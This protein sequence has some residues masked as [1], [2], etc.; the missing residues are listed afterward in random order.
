MKTKNL[1]KRFSPAFAS[2]LLVVVLFASCKDDQRTKYVCNCEEN[3]QIDEFISKNIKNSN[4]MSDEEMEDV[5]YELYKTAVRIK[6]KQK[7][8]WVNNEGVPD[9]QRSGLDSCERV[10][11]NVSMY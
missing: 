6:C 8:I 10:M 4:N 3:K 2:V 9:L 11:N 1:I 5:I 7:M